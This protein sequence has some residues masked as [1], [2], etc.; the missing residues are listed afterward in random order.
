MRRRVLWFA[1]T[2]GAQFDPKSAGPNRSM[3]R[4]RFA[5]GLPDLSAAIRAFIHE[6]DLRHRPIR[7]NDFHDHRQQP[8]AGGAYYRESLDFVMMDIG[9]HAALLHN[10]PQPET[11]LTPQ[12]E[13][14]S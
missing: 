6:V 2:S 7:V 4:L 1:S 13:S 3:P 8:D 10:E 14:P 9:W 5:H 12:R 11:S